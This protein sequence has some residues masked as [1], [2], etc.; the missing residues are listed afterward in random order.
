VRW[1]DDCEI[2][3]G[4][5][6]PPVCQRC[7]LP[8]RIGEKCPDCAIETFLFT[9][10]AS[11]YSYEGPI[12]NALHRLKYNNDLGIADVL[13]MRMSDHLEDLQWRI[14]LVV[15]VPLGRERR[16]ERGYNQSAMLA[17]P[18]AMKLGLKYSSH[19]LK[20]IRE[21]GSQVNLTGEER[22]KNVARAFGANRV[23]VKGMVVL[24]VDDIITTGATMQECS[25]A[26]LDAGA[27]EVYGLSVARTGNRMSAT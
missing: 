22:R 20:R 14:D 10:A 18:L 21:T 3:L 25:R 23:A 15:P 26:L 27:S 4:T 12:K 8:L 5:L 1:C 2:S 16:K 9:R 7:G 11:R 6:P 24:V 19:I 17:Y 13:A